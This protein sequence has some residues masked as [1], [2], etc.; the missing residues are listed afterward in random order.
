MNY[1]CDGRNSAR[2][3]YAAKRK[4][5]L[6]GDYKPFPEDN[7]SRP[8]KQQNVKLHIQ[9]EVRA[10]TNSKMSDIRNEIITP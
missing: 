4:K 2:S 6:T 7:N 5:D 8:S 10:Q 9:N 3:T 1:K